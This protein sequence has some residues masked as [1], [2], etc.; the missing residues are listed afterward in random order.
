MKFEKVTKSLPLND[1]RGQKRSALRNAIEILVKGEC[2]EVRFTAQELAETSI[3]KRA[4]RA[5]MMVGY[6]A[7]INKTGLKKSFSVRMAEN[8]YDVFR[9]A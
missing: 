5:S 6:I 9:T 2:L 7:R 3:Q 8:G 1:T 4:Q